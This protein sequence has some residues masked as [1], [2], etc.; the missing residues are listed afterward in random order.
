MVPALAPA[1][2]GAVEPL[3]CL[4]VPAEH[5]KR[6]A[7]PVGGVADPHDLFRVEPRLAVLDPRALALEQR[8]PLHGGVLHAA[9]HR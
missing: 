4:L 3:A 6:Q 8:L 9:S 7:G 2:R 5:E 1:G